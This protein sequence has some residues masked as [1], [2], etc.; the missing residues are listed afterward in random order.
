M[1]SSRSLLSL[2]FFFPTIIACGFLFKNRYMVQMAVGSLAI[3]STVPGNKKDEGWRGKKDL[4]NNLCL[5]VI[6]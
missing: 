6:Y 2:I 1:K 3:I 5:H 4:F